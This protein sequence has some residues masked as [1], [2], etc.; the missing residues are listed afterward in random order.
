V[1]VSTGEVQRW[2]LG[3]VPTNG[4]VL[5]TAGDVIFFGDLNRRFRAFDA[6]NGKILWETILGSVISSSTITY[7]VNGR[8]YV[9]VI[10][11]DNLAAPGLIAG[12]MG[13]VKV[14]ITPPRGTNAIYVFALP[15]RR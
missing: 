13:P 4:A 9:A 6:D 3:K 14:D 11:G 1:N 7:A 10:A 8:Q 2:A 12:T 5:A 15:Q